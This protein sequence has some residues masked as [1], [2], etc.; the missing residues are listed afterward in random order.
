MIA[1]LDEAG[2]SS[3]SYVWDLDL[4]QSIQGTGGVGGLLAR[5]YEGGAY[6][7]LH[8]RQQRQCRADA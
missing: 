5:I 4:S 2:F 6:V 8:V 1:E 7:F 3:A